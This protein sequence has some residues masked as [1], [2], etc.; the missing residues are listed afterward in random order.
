[1][2]RAESPPAF[3]RRVGATVRAG[4]E[5][6]RLQNETIPKDEN[7]IVVGE[8]ERTAESSGP[9]YRHSHLHKGAEYDA[10]LGSDPFDAFLA[11]RER[12]LLLRLLDR[13]FPR[14]L[15]RYL[16]F[17]CGTGRVLVVWR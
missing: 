8:A 10:A 7:S 2:Q 4:Y 3:V 9:D 5:T 14:G 11:I 17:A 16:D 6:T 13:L 1:M 12:A 15:S